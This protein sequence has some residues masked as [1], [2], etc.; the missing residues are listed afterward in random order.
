MYLIF[1]LIFFFVVLF[2]TRAFVKF[3]MKPRPE[4]EGDFSGVCINKYTGEKGHSGM[5]ASNGNA[6]S[7]G[8][9]DTI[10]YLTLESAQKDRKTF[11]CDASDFGIVNT[12]EKITIHFIKFRSFEVPH[13]ETIK[14]I[15][16]M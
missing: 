16:Q 1:L 2:L 10:Y 14:F 12:G 4:Y 8:H 7:R 9:F 15:D 13:I 3:L 6:L 11:T 5:Y